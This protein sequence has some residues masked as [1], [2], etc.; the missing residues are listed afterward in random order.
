MKSTLIFNIVL[1]STVLI[2]F[3][4]CE[5]DEKNSPTTV[6]IKVLNKSN[7][8]VSLVSVYIFERSVWDKAFTDTKYA[9]AGSITDIKGKAVFSDTV[10]PNPFVSTIDYVNDFMAVIYINNNAVKA[11]PFT[12]YK[13]E[14]KEVIFIN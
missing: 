11:L 2:G 8:P 6:T 13:G 4:A 3:S 5:K 10:N 7:Q 14:Q 12:L 9:L 1:L